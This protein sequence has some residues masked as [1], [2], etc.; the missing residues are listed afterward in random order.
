MKLIKLAYSAIVYV[1]FLGVFNY[2]I[3]FLAGDAL[4]Q[5]FSI[6]AGLK[7]VDSGSVWLAI[8]GLPAVLSNFVILLVF[9]LQH[10]IMARLGFKQLLTRLLPQSAERSTYVLSTCLILLWLYFAWQPMPAMIWQVEGIFVHV[11]AA[12]FLLGAGLVLWSTFMI[13]HW[14]L[15]GLAQAWHAFRGVQPEEKGLTQPAL[16][17]YVRHP[18]YLG[19]FIVLWATPQMTLGHLVMAVVWSVYIFIGISFEERDLIRQFG[20]DY[21]EYMQRVPKLLPWRPKVRLNKTATEIK[22]EHS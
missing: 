12:V 21:Q 17:Q 20:R 15:F 22:L 14:E 5:C 9:S 6:F 4:A 18:L 11:I 10:T 13:S 7:S 1:F 3:I 8:P 2:F 19:L 16:Y